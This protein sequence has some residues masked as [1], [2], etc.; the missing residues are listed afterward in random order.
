MAAQI[1]SGYRQFGLGKITRRLVS[2]ALFEGRPHTTKGQWFNPVVFTLLRTLKVIPGN[3]RITSPIFIT[4]LGRSGTTIL[5]LLFSLHRDVGFLNEPKAIWSLVNEHSDVC[6][7]YLC[8]GGHFRLSPTEATEQQ[9][10]SAHRMF[11][12]YLRFTGSTRLIDKYPELIF[13]IDYLLKIFPDAR[14]IFISRNGPDAVASIELWSRRLGIAKAGGRTEDWWGRND[15]KWTYLREQLLQEDSRWQSLREVATQDLDHLNR[16]AIEWIISMQEG[17]K[18]LKSHPEAVCRLE[19][20]KLVN[21]PQ[22]EIARLLEYCH[23]SPDA[24]VFDYANKS[25]YPRPHN[26]WPQLLPPHR[27]AV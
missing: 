7:D 15:L 21:D 16:A 24:A 2:Y 10:Q 18:Q 17:L 14:V 19:Y 27:G 8:S 25:L 9:I 26:T 5:G 3:P 4:G 22:Q 20:E 23:L 12:R 6:G 1:D 13:R 11:S